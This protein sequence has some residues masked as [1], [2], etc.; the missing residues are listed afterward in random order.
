MPI[1]Q[2]PTNSFK[3]ELLAGQHNFTP[4]TGHTF[5]VALYSD[6][7][8]LGPLTT[9][10]SATNEISGTGYTAGGAVVTSNGITVSGSTAYVDFADL[11]WVGASFTARAALIYN[12][13]TGGGSGTTEALWVL[14]FGSNKTASAT[15]FVI[16]FPAPDSA[17]A[18]LRIT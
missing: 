11:T 8:D 13:T 12:T 4:G 3:A 14:D 18:V 9:D 5:R 15:N 6:V 16:Q 7:A 10:Y 1:I 17:N 2:G